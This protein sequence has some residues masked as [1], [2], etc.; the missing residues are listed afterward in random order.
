MIDPWLVGQW[1]GQR[2]TSPAFW[3]IP[4][5]E[6]YLKLEFP[7]KDWITCQWSKLCTSFKIFDIHYNLAKN[8]P[9][10]HLCP[11]GPACSRW[12]SQ[13]QWL[14]R[15]PQPTRSPSVTILYQCLF[16]LILFHCFLFCFFISIWSS[17]SPPSSSSPCAS[18]PPSRNAGHP[19]WSSLCSRCLAGNA[20]GASQIGV[21][22]LPLILFFL[23]WSNPSNL[24]VLAIPRFSAQSLKL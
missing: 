18:S 19:W 11:G 8:F 17:R 4:G 22:E 3:D 1:W 16:P 21:L 2:L 24:F 14:L 10:K 5:P 6:Y 13:Y 23:T 9:L 12:S 7:S 20:W 15:C